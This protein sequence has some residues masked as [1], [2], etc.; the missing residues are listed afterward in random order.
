LHQ[1]HASVD[2]VLLTRLEQLIEGTAGSAGR[3]HERM[4]QLSGWLARLARESG[5]RCPVEVTVDRRC[6]IG[7]LTTRTKMSGHVFK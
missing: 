3:K 2:P 6:G 5:E 4:R 7:T 1:E